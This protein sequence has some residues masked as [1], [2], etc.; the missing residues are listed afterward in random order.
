MI[1]IT[2]KKIPKVY[3]SKFQLIFINELKLRSHLKLY[4]NGHFLQFRY[5]KIKKIF[6]KT[7]EDFYVRSHEILQR[8]LKRSSEIS[9]EFLFKAFDKSFLI[10]IFKRSKE[11]ICED[12][13][14]I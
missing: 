7:S 2:L 4:K 5:R 8:F 11:K 3:I 10:K 1:D 9:P 14:N 13:Y 12:T 6:F